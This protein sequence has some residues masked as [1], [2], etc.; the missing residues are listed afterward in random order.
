[1]QFYACRLHRTKLNNYHLIQQFTSGYLS[2]INKN[3]NS[4]KKKCWRGLPFPPPGD[5]PDPGIKPTSLHWQMISLPLAPHGSGLQHI[6]WGLKSTHDQDIKGGKTSIQ[7]LQKTRIAVYQK[8]AGG[9]RERYWPHTTKHK[10]NDSVWDKARPE[11]SRAK[12]N[13]NKDDPTAN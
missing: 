3:I 2:A 9:W 13:E 12:R 6:F 1:M 4:K 8:L 5:L 10:G 11:A 7:L